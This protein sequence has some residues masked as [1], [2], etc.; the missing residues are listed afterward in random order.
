MAQAL[1]RSAFALGWSVDPARCVFVVSWMRSGSSL[2]SNIMISNASLFGIGETHVRHS[3]T[4]TLTEAALVAAIVR[5][6]LPPP[7]FRLFDKI[8]HNHLDARMEDRILKQARFVFLTR[9][10]SASSLSIQTMWNKSPQVRYPSEFVYL[11]ERISRLQTLTSEIPQQNRMILDYEDILTGSPAFKLL[12]AF[13]G[14]TISQAY[15]TQPYIGRP[16]IG[17]YSARIGS[18]RVLNRPTI[19]ATDAPLGE[20]ELL[21]LQQQVRGLNNAF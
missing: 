11:S 16:G 8:L 9:D 5:R 7:R 14:A 18:G 20:D 12:G 1:G 6:E 10:L 4:V 15:S 17:D 19:R 3:T 2:L 21:A 13:L